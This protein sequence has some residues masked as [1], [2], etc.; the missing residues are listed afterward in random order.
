MQKTQNI[1]PIQSDFQIITNVQRMPELIQFIEWYAVPKKF[2]N[3]RDQ[4]GFAKKIGVCEDTITNWKNHDAFLPLLQKAMKK[5]M[6][7]HV[8]D[9]IGGLYT[10]ACSK[11]HAKDVEMYLRISGINNIN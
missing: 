5:W 2:R 4:K 10:K 6:I 9:V 3:P 7:D 11:G 8:P 1:I